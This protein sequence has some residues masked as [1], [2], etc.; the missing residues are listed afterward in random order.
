M[1]FWSS[2]STISYFRSR[3]KLLTPF[4]SLRVTIGGVNAPICHGA[5]RRHKTISD[6]VIAIEYVDANG[7]VQMVTD[8]TQLKAAAGCFGLLGIVTH[9]TFELEAMT[10]AVLKPLKTPISLAIPPLQM[11]DVP[12]A[13]YKNWTEKDIAA[14]QADFE[15][16]ATNDFYSEWFWYTYQSTAWVN[17]WNPT[18]DS[19]GAEE[20]PSPAGVF[21]QWVQCWLGGWFSQTFFFRNIPGRWQAQF[22]AI[23]GMAVLPPTLFDIGPVEYKTQLPNGLHFFRGVRFSFH[24]NCPSDREFSNVI[25]DSKLSRP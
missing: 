23:A 12:L 2:Q 17:S 1:S 16:R 20:F 4:R 14:A 18:D 15:K 21:L 22:L 5:G 24:S 11:S 8:P 10:Y 25:T 19:E 3:S 6:Q 9:I 7:A 13:L